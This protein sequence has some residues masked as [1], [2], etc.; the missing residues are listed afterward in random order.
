MASTSNH[1]AGRRRPT[2][3]F[4]LVT[5]A[6]I[7]L[8]ANQSS[9]L[10][11]KGTSVFASAQDVAGKFATRAKL[12]TTTKKKEK[13]RFFWGNRRGEEESNEDVGRDGE[14]DGSLWRRL[15]RIVDG[16]VG[17][18]SWEW[19]MFLAESRIIFLSIIVSILCAF[20]PF[21]W[22]LIPEKRTSA[23][24]DGAE[25]GG[26]FDVPTCS[27]PLSLFVL[28]LDPLCL[29]CMFFFFAFIVYF[30]LHSR[31]LTSCIDRC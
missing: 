18:S 2:P 25:G 9:Q 12:I 3:L 28:Y 24:R 17:S 7:T 1:F 6:F 16:D 20:L 10:H 5:I 31:R 14:F 8:Y 19:D 15:R 30:S 23:G 26:E 22:Y 13:N 27:C 11:Q 29:V 21:L 4:T